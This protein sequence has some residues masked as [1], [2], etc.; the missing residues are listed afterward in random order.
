MFLENKLYE[1]WNSVRIYFNILKLS[2][3]AEDVNCDLHCVLNAWTSLDEISS[4]SFL[5]FMVK[6]N[7]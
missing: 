7:Y 6:L 5:K 2:L 3:P 1:K 4:K